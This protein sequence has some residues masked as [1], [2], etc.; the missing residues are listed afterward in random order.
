M[1]HALTCLAHRT[2]ARRRTTTASDTHAHAQRIWHRSR[3]RMTAEA[4]ARGAHTPRTP[5]ALRGSAHELRRHAAFWKRVRKC[6]DGLPRRAFGSPL[7]VCALPKGEGGQVHAD[8]LSV[9]WRL[10]GVLGLLEATLGRARGGVNGCF[11][12]GDDE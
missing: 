12:S 5:V 10:A 11:S 6:S 8:L 7:G 9:L 2:R 3:I 4:L 1:R